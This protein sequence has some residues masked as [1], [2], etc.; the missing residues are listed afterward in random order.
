MSIPLAPDSTIRVRS[1]DTVAGGTVSVPDPKRV[2]HLQFR[3]FA[4]CPICHTH[5][6]SIAKRH[7]E[8]RSAGIREVV[9][10]H[11][12]IDELYEYTDMLPFDV[13]ADPDKRVYREFGV[14]SARRAIL[15]LGGLWAV[16]RTAIPTTVR[17]L[18]GRQRPPS[19]KPEGGRLGLPADLL[20][21]PDG[22]VLAAHYGEHMDDQW[23][24]DELL[25]LAA[26]VTSPRR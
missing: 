11:T 23:S 1:F 19:S 8:I 26:E 25:R 7:D 12:G 17:I 5:L 18:T 9:F 10:F 22:R 20:I 21:A 15:S 6:R 14:E 16:L 4:G 3:R 24:V 2:V 13:V